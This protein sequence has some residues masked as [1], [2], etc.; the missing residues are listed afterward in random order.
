LLTTERD[1]ELVLTTGTSDDCVPEA[2]LG[3]KIWIRYE[4]GLVAALA[5]NGHE[6]L[7]QAW[8]S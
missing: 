5:T 6:K 2:M 7:C 1:V 3:L 8:G 4:L